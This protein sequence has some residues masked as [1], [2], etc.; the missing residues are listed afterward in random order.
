MNSSFQTDNKRGIWVAYSVK[1]PTSDRVMI[2]WFVDSSPVSG[3]VLTVQSLGPASDSV[4][5]SRSNP[6]PLTLCLYLCLPLSTMNI[7]RDLNKGN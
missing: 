3:S 7:T 5:P 4:S 6:A 2:S 1:Y